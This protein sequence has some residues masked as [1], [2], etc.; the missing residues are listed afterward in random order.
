M[1]FCLFSHLHKLSVLM[2][3]RTGLGFRIQD[4]GSGAK[5]HQR[6][7]YLIKDFLSK[8]LFV[9]PFFWFVLYLQTALVL[10]CEIVFTDIF[11]VV[12]YNFYQSPFALTK[13]PF[14]L[15][16]ITSVLND[17]Q[18]YLLIKEM[19]VNIGITGYWNHQKRKFAS[20]LFHCLPR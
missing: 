12:Y 18:E 11:T 2:H 5:V 10:L 6:P 3:F 14:G 19:F 9:F 17:Q 4:Q 1:I 15:I 8:Q 13:I 20:G 7:N 16:L